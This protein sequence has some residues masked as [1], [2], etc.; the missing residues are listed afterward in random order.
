[1]GDDH[2]GK[3]DAQ[4]ADAAGWSE[5]Y[6]A[7][8]HDRLGRTQ[9]A[10]QQWLAT[11]T[12]LLGLFSV[13][14]VVGGGKSV[15]DL[16]HSQR[17]GVFVGAVVVYFLAFVSV[18]MGALATWGGLSGRTA[19]GKELAEYIANEKGMAKKAVKD[20]K[21]Y[22]RRAADE[23]DADAKAAAVE[24]ATAK[25][26]QADMHWHQVRLARAVL[27]AGTI[28]SPPRWRVLWG[29]DLPT[30]DTFDYRFRYERLANRRRYR[31]HQS[32]IF[33]IL[34]AVLSGILAMIVLGLQTL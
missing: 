4:E 23:A 27:D 33:G 30:G 6:Q 13:A 7:F 14:I 20:S 34:T 31:L 24:L 19:D 15:S 26:Q 32:R 2:Q 18:L 12:A 5:N 21:E 29:S 8:F 28:D 11:I 1:V 10:A 17:L 3:A 16:P 25:E 9:S 22:R